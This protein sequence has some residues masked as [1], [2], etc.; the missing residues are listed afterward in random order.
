MAWED[1]QSKLDEL[2]SAGRLRTLQ[3]LRPS[4]VRLIAPDGCSL[5]NF[6]SN[7]YLNLAGNAVSRPPTSESQSVGARASGLVCGWTP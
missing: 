7:D 5:V 1:F 6:G 2:H 4:G 3:T